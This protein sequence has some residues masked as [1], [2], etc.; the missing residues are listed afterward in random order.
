MPRR[1][2]RSSSIHTDGISV[3]DSESS[4]RTDGIS[5]PDPGNPRILL[6]LVGTWSEH[7]PS[8]EVRTLPN[9]VSPPFYHI[10]DITPQPSPWSHTTVR[11]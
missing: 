2:P 3:P 10:G 1:R 7:D 11:F 6:T 8:W 4:I 5:V 9:T